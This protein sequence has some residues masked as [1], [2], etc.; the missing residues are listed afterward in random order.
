VKIDITK[1]AQ[2]QIDRIEA[3]WHANRDKAPE[4]FADELERAKEFLRTTPKLA[5]VYAIRG[6]REIRWLV[7][8]KTK[9]MLHFWVDEKADV[10]HVVSAWGGKRG[11][12]PKL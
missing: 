1:R 12:G 6:S 4:L 3:W 10:V 5:K 9:V 11:S 7:L 2:G 8:P